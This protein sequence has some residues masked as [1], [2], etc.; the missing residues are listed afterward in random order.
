LFF[1]Y[2]NSGAEGA[3]IFILSHIESV[4][5]LRNRLWLPSHTHSLP[6]REGREGLGFPLGSPEGGEA[7]TLWLSAPTNPPTVK[8]KEG[9]DGCWG[10]AKGLLQLCVCN[11]PSAGSPTETLLRLLLPLN[12]KV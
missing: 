10:F 3:E 6:A 2:Y 1:V 11:D 9:G 5:A 4:D 7:G 8:T 12:D